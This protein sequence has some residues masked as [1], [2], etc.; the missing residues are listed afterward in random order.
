MAVT[1]RVAEPGTCL[2]L[3]SQ[4]GGF[5]MGNEASPGLSIEDRKQIAGGLF[6][7]DDTSVREPSRTSFRTSTIRESNGLPASVNALRLVRRFSHSRGRALPRASLGHVARGR[8]EAILPSTT[9][10]MMGATLA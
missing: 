6:F 10:I 8:M 3:L 1:A 7:I 9:R 4:I 2:G 5:E